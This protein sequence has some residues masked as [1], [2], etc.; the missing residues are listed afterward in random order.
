ME[1]QARP[2]EQ[3]FDVGQAHYQEIAQALLSAKSAARSVVSSCQALI[4]IANK[5]TAD[6]LT[7]IA[8]SSQVNAD[9]LSQ[10]YAIISKYAFQ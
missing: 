5:S 2:S 4:P 6:E 10:I 8:L 7:A 3:L 9:L 1:D